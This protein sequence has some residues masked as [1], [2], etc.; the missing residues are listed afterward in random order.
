MANQ[1][2]SMNEVKQI[3]L[4]YQQD[5]PIKQIAR[6]L[7]MSKNTVKAYLRRFDATGLR[8]EDAVELPCPELQAHLESPGL[9]DQERFKAFL[10]QAPRYV[11]E[12]QTHRHLTKL[13]LW[14]EE[15]AAGR[16]AYRYSQFCH[17]LVQFEKNKS[18]TMIMHHVAGDKMFMDFAGDK[19]SY[20]DTHSG[21]LTPCEILLL[22]LGYS[23]Y[24]RVVA[25]PSQ[26]IE[27]TIDGLV[28]CFTE[29]GGVCKAI[30]P[31]NFKA[32]VTKAN[33]YEPRINERFLDLCNYYGVSVLPARVASPKDKPKVETAVKNV[34]QRIY[35]GLRNQNF[36]SLEELNK[37]LKE[38]CELFNDRMMKDYGA[39]RRELFEREEKDLLVELPREKYEMVNQHSLKVQPNN[40]VHLRGKKKHFSVP[41]HLI[42]Q[43]VSLLYSNKVVRIYHKG[44]CVATH[45][46]P[47][48]RY[49][50]HADHMGSTHR[51]YLNS[52]NPDTLRAHGHAIDQS[53]GEVIDRMLQRPMHPEQN[54][55]SCQGVLSLA[56]KYALPK[57][58]EA[59]KIALAADIVGYGY[60][61]R[62]CTNQYS[63]LETEPAYNDPLPSHYNIR[64]N[65]F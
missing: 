23:N 54:Y 3:L 43:Q 56:R 22:T 62:I 24:T 36:G 63:S 1:S 65:Y 4:L 40:H 60:I 47:F 8:K 57:L 34:Y 45:A 41:H 25:I 38:R 20:T 32:A 59:C 2:I 30:V 46:A 7:G 26:R 21:K 9:Q 12:L 44:E 16:T 33:R 27:D 64:G 58:V 55:K 61:Q 15:F 35:A 31:D 50:S 48:Q 51:E 14:E 10:E 18:G 19:L 39:S 42:G 52:I 11:Q 5:V 17:H 28:Q 13:L 49:S 29:L 53:V 37:A 6:Q